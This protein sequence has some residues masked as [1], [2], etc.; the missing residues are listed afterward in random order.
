MAVAGL[1]PQCAEGRSGPSPRAPCSLRPGS[2]RP[3][4]EG[5]LPAG[6][7]PHAR[8]LR[9]AI[10]SRRIHAAVEGGGGDASEGKGP[11]RRPQRR[12]GRRLEE[13]A[14]AV[15]GGYCRLHM[16]LRL[17]LGVRGTAAGHRLGAL[18]GG[19]GAVP[20]LLPMHPMGRGLGRRG[21]HCVGHVDR[22]GGPAR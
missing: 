5:L 19:G 3:V 6:L 4:C 7:G 9:T 16:P 13:V 8:G 12:L 22:M 20:P 2:C 1:P 17:A 14:K 18:K 10:A 21:G 15:G 11:Q